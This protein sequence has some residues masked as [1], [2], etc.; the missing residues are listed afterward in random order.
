MTETK[1]TP[2]PWMAD[3]DIACTFDDDGRREFVIEITNLDHSATVAYA[4]PGYENQIV[5]AC[6][7]HDQLVE[8]LNRVACCAETASHLLRESSPVESRLFKKDAE[9]ARSAL[10]S[11]GNDG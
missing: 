10:E 11:V 9:F 2:T 7:A 1:H 5:T 3:V 6:N 8:A 4:V